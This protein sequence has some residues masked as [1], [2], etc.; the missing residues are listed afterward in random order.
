MGRLL[1][2][3]NFLSGALCAISSPLLG[4]WSDRY[5]RKPIIAF[6][7]LGMFSG[8]AVSI[9]A[10]WY[11]HR[12]PAPL[13]LLEFVLGGLTGAF[14]T[15]LAMMQ[16]Y[17][18]DVTSRDKRLNVFSHLHA[19]MYLGLALGPAGAA[20]AARSIGSGDILPVFYAA[21]IIHTCFIAYVLICIPESFPKSIT[22]RSVQATTASSSSSPS[23]TAE[24]TIP[25]SPP[26]ID[27]SGRIVDRRCA[28]HLCNFVPLA[29]LSPSAATCS[30]SRYNLLILATIDAFA[31]GVYTGLSPLLILFAEYHFG[32]KSLEA[33]IFVTTT[34]VIRAIMLAC[35]VP[36]VV[37]V[38]ASSRTK[39]RESPTLRHSE[40]NL[41]NIFI[42]RL[43]LLLAL[44]S[45]LGF[46]LSNQTPI[47]VASG[48][49]SAA[50]VPA[51]TVAQSMMA[52]EVPATRVGELFGAVGLL[53]AASRA[54][55]PAMMY[56]VYSLIVHTAPTTLFWCLGG[57]FG[58]V[59]LLAQG[60]HS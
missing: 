59:S 28:P 1:G 8:D 58:L 49:L 40:T 53:H 17:A 13:I 52:N 38:T 45:N 23:T 39:G 35:I 27:K 29:I 57:C 37:A 4:K 46:A 31:F 7:A 10:A 44:F 30:R 20:F 16:S 56:F 9:V 48:I 19:S 42:I 22:L 24:P 41:I 47:F 6:S 14:L 25:D 34:N 3:G 32:W 2:C 12:F 60:L 18:A 36:A 51:S 54:I 50:S 33:S 5:G 55:V 21:G 11:P 15:T 43:S 26:A